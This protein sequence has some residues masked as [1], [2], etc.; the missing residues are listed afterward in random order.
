MTI[1]GAPPERPPDGSGTMTGT[2]PLAAGRGPLRRLWRMAGLVLDAALLATL[3]LVLFVGYGLIDNRWYHLVAVR[4]GSM[5]P[6]IEPG[7]LI[8]ITR[9]PTRVEPGMILTLEVD[10]AVVT[11]RVV[12]VQADGSFVTKGD[13][14]DVRDDFSGHTVR[15]VGEY[16]ARIPG[17]GGLL[18]V[19]EPRKLGSTGAWF[20]GGATLGA[21]GSG[22]TWLTTTTAGT[23]G[24]TTSGIAATPPPTTRAEPVP[25]TAT[26]TPS[27]TPTLAPS[28]EATGSAPPSPRPTPPITPGASLEPTPVP[29]ASPTASPSPSEDPGPTP[30]PSEPSPPPVDPPPTPSPTDSPPA[31]PSNAS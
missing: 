20:D 21:S 9:P 19:G 7:D 18:P 29:T 14:N 6:T 24:M 8:V 5:A 13:A 30:A 17:L 16:Q 25:S 1:L 22:G 26:V 2:P 10:G 28:A 27:P 15:V 4:G 3:V 12:Q 11:H 23:S 31:S